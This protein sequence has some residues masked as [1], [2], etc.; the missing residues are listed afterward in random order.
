MSETY[1]F[2][3][4]WWGSIIGLSWMKLASLEVTSRWLH[5]PIVLATK[6][7][8]K[9]SKVKLKI[10]KHLRQI[11]ET[12]MNFHRPRLLGLKRGLA[13]GIISQRSKQTIVPNRTYVSPMRADAAAGRERTIGL[14]PVSVLATQ[15]G[16][17]RLKT[18]S[19]FII[20][21]MLI[22]GCLL[23]LLKEIGGLLKNLSEETIWEATRGLQATQEGRELPLLSKIPISLLGDVL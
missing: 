9:V 20:T 21:N 14:W 15:E 11:K 19:S 7:K 4:W 1:E 13:N 16:R 12:R 10:L 6:I 22:G 3:C 2:R 23:I 8:V 17:K 18:F 5:P